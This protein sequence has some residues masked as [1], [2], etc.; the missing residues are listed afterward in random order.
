MKNSPDQNA[1]E[2]IIDNV[3]RLFDNF[4]G[5]FRRQPQD[6][7][8]DVPQN[9]LPN[10]FQTV[11]PNVGQDRSTSEPIEQGNQSDQL[12]SPQGNQSSRRSSRQ[13][14]RQ[15]SSTEYSTKQS[16]DNKK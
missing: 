11:S 1:F 14:N 4:V 15:S 5:M 16:K 10:V 3:R 2:T 6:A 8:T 9:L 13:S 7:S 12:S